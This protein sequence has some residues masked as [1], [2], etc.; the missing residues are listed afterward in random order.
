[1]AMGGTL[2]AWWFHC[3]AYQSIVQIPMHNPLFPRAQ[4]VASRRWYFWVNTVA[5]SPYLS[6]TSRKRIY[7]AMGMDIDPGAYEIGSGCYFHSADLRIGPGS[8]INDRCWFENT[9]RVTIGAGVAVA[10]H[11]RVITSTH[12]IG[13]SSSRVS[14]GWEYHPVTLEDG[15]WLGA[16]VLVQPGVTI[17]RGCIIAPGAVVAVD[18]EPDWL[19]GGVPARKL[20]QLDEVE[21][22]TTL[23]TLESLHIARARMRA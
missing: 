13:P 8:R 7:C 14:G 23:R 15:C 10:P 20:R 9:G 12:R 5:A 3:A 21:R 1:M 22:V 17:G 11:V 19:Y 6:P 2:P 4:Y 16:G 18:T